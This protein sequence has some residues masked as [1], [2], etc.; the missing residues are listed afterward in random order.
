MR[1]LYLPIAVCAGLCFTNTAALAEQSISGSELRK[2][3]VGKKLQDT[4]R[5]DHWVKLSADGTGV[6]ASRG[7]DFEMTYEIK[8]DG[9]WCRN[10][11]A[12]R[13]NPYKCQ[14]VKVDGNVLIFKNEDGSTSSRMRVE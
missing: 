11:P 7:Y 4:A 9:T 10:I 12:A 8:D 1:K 13:R 3:V 2:M 5:D 14:S 6:G